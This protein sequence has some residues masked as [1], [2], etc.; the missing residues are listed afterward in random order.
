VL[1]RSFSARVL[2]RNRWR[3][4]RVNYR[5]SA[6]ARFTVP[7]LDP[8]GGPA[9]RAAQAAAERLAA[10]LADERGLFPEHLFAKAR[11]V[12]EGAPMQEGNLDLTDADRLVPSYAQALFTL[13]EIGRTSK[14]VRTQWGWDVLLWTKELPPRELSEPALAAELFP[15]SRLAFFTAWS[16]SVGR[17]VRVTVNPA[18][19]A[20]LAR[21]AQPAGDD[22][23]PTGPA[24]SSPTPASPLAAPA[25][26]R[27]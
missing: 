17:N 5:G 27:P 7:E 16:K 18:A 6:F 11:E 26:A 2:E 24:A 15:E 3:L 23:P 12:S 1:F 9:D 4:H 14:A 10:A 25:E 19:E 22:G 21:L 13:P 20:L 8:P